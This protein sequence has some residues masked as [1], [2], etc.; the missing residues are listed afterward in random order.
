[1][2]AAAIFGLDRFA[3]V[4]PMTVAGALA[5]SPVEVGSC[6]KRVTLGGMTMNLLLTAAKIVLGLF[7]KS[8]V[9]WM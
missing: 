2:V 6:V 3:G 5:L 1:M 4:V 8:H 7:C 9:L